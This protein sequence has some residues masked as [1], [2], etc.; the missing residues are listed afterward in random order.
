MSLCRGVNFHS[1]SR[2]LRELRARKRRRRA[3]SA[4]VAPLAP[5]G[6]AAL[7]VNDTSVVAV[8]EGHHVRCVYWKA[9]GHCWQ[10]EVLRPEDGLWYRWYFSNNQGA[11]RDETSRLWCYLATGMQAVTYSDKHTI[12]DSPAPQTHRFSITATGTPQLVL[13]NSIGVTDNFGSAKTATDSHN[14]VLGCSG[15]RALE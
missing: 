12:T 14:D 8:R 10:P 5:P 3:A 1:R 15:Y 11:T 6:T 9:D 13:A 4:M 7:V 2:H